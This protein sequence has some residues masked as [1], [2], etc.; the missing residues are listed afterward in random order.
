VT[1]TQLIIDCDPG[2]DD[3]IALFMAFASR[4]ELDIIAITTVGGNVG[5]DLTARNARIIRE[6]AGREDVPVHAGA[7][8]PLVRAPVAA[9]DFHGASG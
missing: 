6:L 3:A 1:R 7:R 8:S 2:V 5:A 9:G 4:E